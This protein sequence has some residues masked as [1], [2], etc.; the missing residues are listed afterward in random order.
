MNNWI[1]AVLEGERLRPR[2]RRFPASSIPMLLMF[3]AVLIWAQPVHGQQLVLNHINDTNLNV[4]LNPTLTIT[5]SV[6][7]TV[8]LNSLIWSLGSGAPIGAS[9][10]NSS[11]PNTA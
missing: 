7:N 5:V 2:R 1:Q 11:P 10:T 9:I 6:T 3:G 8:A 4:T